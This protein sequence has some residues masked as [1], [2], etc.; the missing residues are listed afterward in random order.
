M[1]EITDDGV[2]IVFLDIIIFSLFKVVY[3]KVSIGC[4]IS[5][6]DSI[7]QIW[8]HSQNKKL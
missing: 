4:R 1:V 6:L 2:K 3:N 8:S 7:E 5:F